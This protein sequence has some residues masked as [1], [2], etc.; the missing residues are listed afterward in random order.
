MLARSQVTAQGEEEQEEPAGPAPAA[1]ALGRRRLGRLRRRRRRGGG[2]GRAH[3]WTCG[4]RAWEGL[5]RATRAARARGQAH[6][7]W[8]LRRLRRRRLSG[9]GGS[10]LLGP[11]AYA[12]R[13]SSKDRRGAGQKGY[14][15]IDEPAPIACLVSCCS[16]GLELTFNQTR[17][18]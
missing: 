2:V 12:I 11:C 3:G 17:K 15:S 18:W 13:C 16:L 4:Q 9:G 7:R 5:L 8:H 6:R 10:G 14:R 1:A